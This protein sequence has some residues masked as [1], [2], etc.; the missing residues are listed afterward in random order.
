MADRLALALRSTADANEAAK[1]G[2][3][4]LVNGKGKNGNVKLIKSG[5]VSI[6]GS[7]TGA[8]K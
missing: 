7:D 8:S 3:E 1:P 4:Y 2:A 6:I 5:E